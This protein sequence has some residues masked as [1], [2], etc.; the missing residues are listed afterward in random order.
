MSG[1]RIMCDGRRHVAGYMEP[2]GDMCPVMGDTLHIDV[3]RTSVA[4]NSGVLIFW[5]C[6]RHAGRAGEDV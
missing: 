3:R 2:I 1:A 5:D 4:A 6:R